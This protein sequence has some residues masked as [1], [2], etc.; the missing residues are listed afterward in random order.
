MGFIRRCIRRLKWRTKTGDVMNHD[1]PIHEGI[2]TI[3][4]ENDCD[5]S[6][7]SE[8]CICIVTWNMNGQVSYGDIKE[9]VGRDRKFHLLVVGLQEAPRNNI[10]RF[11]QEAL[12]ETHMKAIMQSVQLYVFGLKNSELFIQEIKMDKYAV[13]GCGGLIRRKKGAVAIRMNYN[14]IHMVFISGHLSA[15][16]SNVEE[17]NSQF[18]HISSSLFSKN[19]NPYARPDQ[20]TIWLGDLNY[21]LQGI[22]TFPARS[23]IRK[24]LHELLTSKDQ[25]LQEAERGQIFSGYC[26]GTLAF[27]PTY[28]YD[29]GSSSYDTSHKVRVPSWTDRILFKIEDIDKI[30]ATLHSYES[31]ETIHSSDHR[32]VKAH[33]CLKLNTQPSPISNKVRV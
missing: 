15:H 19:L 25:L 4:V 21:R 23:L 12:V 22:N 18:R 27:K 9:L 11:L 17:R 5:F 31:I 6:S 30:N 26:E 8:L 28:K 13:G 33:L 29:I 16:T 20:I 32:P 1:I 24:N 2:K 7:S 10:S 14:G 3:G